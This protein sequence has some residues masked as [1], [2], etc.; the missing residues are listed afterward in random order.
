MTRTFS[1]VVQKLLGDLLGSPGRD[2]SKPVPKRSPEYR[3]LTAAA[4]RTAGDY[5]Y[6]FTNDEL[7]ERAVRSLRSRLGEG[8]APQ[9]KT[10]AQYLDLLLANR[11]QCSDET[12]HAFFSQEDVARYLSQ[13]DA[14]DEVARSARVLRDEILRAGRRRRVYLVFGATWPSVDPVKVEGGVR[15]CKAIGDALGCRSNYLIVHGGRNTPV[16]QEAAKACEASLDAAGCEHRLLTYVP[17]ENAD[18][19]SRDRHNYI[20]VGRT[21]PTPMS[22][23]ERKRYLVDRSDAILVMGGTNTTDY[24]SDFVRDRRDPS[25]VEPDVRGR[26]TNLGVPVA[27]IGLPHL[28]GVGEEYWRRGIGYALEGWRDAPSDLWLALGEKMALEETVAD[29]T[30]QLLEWTFTNWPGVPSGV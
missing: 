20:G 14:A 6:D 29:L 30:L 8:R 12:L 7:C 22:P 1:G 25:I 3:R 15:I 17:R 18:E 9:D 13:S 21:I 27:V 10:T 28:E 24:V 23:K 5:W 19:A 11:D 16:L 26:Y 4:K 2:F